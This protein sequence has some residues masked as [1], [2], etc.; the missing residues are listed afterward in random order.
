MSDVDVRG[1]LWTYIGATRSYGPACWRK[2]GVYCT[3]SQAS[4]GGAALLTPALVQVQDD[5]C[6]CTDLPGYCW[7]QLGGKE[8]SQAHL[9]S[10][11]RRAPASAGQLDQAAD[12]NI[13]S[14]QVRQRRSFALGVLGHIYANVNRGLRTTRSDK[15]NVN[16]VSR[17][18]T[19][20]Q[21]TAVERLQQHT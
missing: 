21:L 10:T 7:L 17:K 4:V 8:G 1:P 18:T 14:Q 2:C 13:C 16:K 11:H 5:G 3:K 6:L 15:L 9:P 12:H 19:S 20:D